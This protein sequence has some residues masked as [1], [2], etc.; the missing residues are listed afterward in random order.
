MHEQK[1]GRGLNFNSLVNQV[2][3]QRIIWLATDHLLQCPEYTALFV[4]SKWYCLLC[5]DML[6]HVSYIQERF[7]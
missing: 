7:T 6:K 1:N 2:S 3:Q 5:S 4:S